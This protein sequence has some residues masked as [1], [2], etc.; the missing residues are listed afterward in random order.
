VVFADADDVSDGGKVDDA[1]VEI[2]VDDDEVEVEDDGE[3]KSVCGVGCSRGRCSGQAESGKKGD[4]EAEVARDG[5]VDRCGDRRG[6]RSGSPYVEVSGFW[7]GGIGD[8]AQA[9]GGWAIAGSGG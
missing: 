3:R 5:G 4:A 6:G 2:D 9:W 7:T 1:E 8:G